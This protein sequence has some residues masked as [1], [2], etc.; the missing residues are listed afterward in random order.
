MYDVV[1]ATSSDCLREAIEEL[2][3]KVNKK[4]AE[5]WRTVG[6]IDTNTKYPFDPEDMDIPSF[7][8]ACQAMEKD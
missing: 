6:G 7:Y 1:M 4:K 5:G 8:Y 2:V 3:E